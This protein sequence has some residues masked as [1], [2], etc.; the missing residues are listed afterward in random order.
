MRDRGSPRVAIPQVCSEMGN[1]N[2][3]TT[4]RASARPRLSDEWGRTDASPASWST[5]SF[6]FLNGVATPYWAAVR[7]LLED[8]FADF[9]SSASPSKGRDLRNQVPHLDRGVVIDRDEVED[10]ADHSCRSTTTTFLFSSLECANDR[11][12]VRPELSMNVT[13]VMSSQTSP[14]VWKP[15]R[16]AVSSRAL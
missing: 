10:R 15:R 4:S 9:W 8:W 11:I 12:E 6:E 5:G 16:A 13:S 3:Q 2:R 7:D 14:S 1:A